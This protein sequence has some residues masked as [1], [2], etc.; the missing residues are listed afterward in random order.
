MPYKDISFL[1]DN[2]KNNLPKEAQII[3]M[4]AFNNAFEEYKDKT[5][6]KTDSS[7]EVTCFK[8]AW[9]AVKKK[10]FKNEEGKWVKK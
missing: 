10:Y 5:K 1:P 7:L 4:K 3:Y 8:I 9:S 6:R 2:I